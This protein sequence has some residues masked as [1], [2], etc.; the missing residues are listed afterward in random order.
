MAAKKRHPSLDGLR[1]VSISMVLFAH[2]AGTPSAYPES[3]RNYTGEL[4]ALGVQVF[5]VISGFLITTLLLREHEKTGQISLKRFYAR[6]VLRIF[7]AFYTFLLAIAILG[8][9]RIEQISWTTWR[10]PLPTERILVGS[11]GFSRIAGLYR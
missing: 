1:A 2:A 9:L 5:F 8:W 7:P 6:R 10:E 4:G 11:A 3:W